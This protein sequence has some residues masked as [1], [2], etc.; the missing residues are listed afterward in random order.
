[1][2]PAC[3]LK[4]YSLWQGE[5]TRTKDDTESSKQRSESQAQLLSH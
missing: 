3:H 4:F 1:M 2:G 5:N